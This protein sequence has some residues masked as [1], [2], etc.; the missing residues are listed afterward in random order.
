MV[1]VCG[2]VQ[3]GVVELFD[4][5]LYCHRIWSLEVARGV[6]RE[7]GT[8]CYYFVARARDIYSCLPNSNKNNYHHLQILGLEY[9]KTAS[10]FRKLH[11][12]VPQLIFTNDQTSLGTKRQS[13]LSGPSEA[14]YNSDQELD[15]ALLHETVS[16]V[17]DIEGEIESDSSGQRRTCTSTVYREPYTRCPML[18]D[19]MKTNFENIS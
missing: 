19:L 8:W 10:G 2:I 9:S 15:V 1:R 13:N 4:L 7:R 14:E 12:S 11:S 16:F 17:L 6:K 5:L 3:E 18:S